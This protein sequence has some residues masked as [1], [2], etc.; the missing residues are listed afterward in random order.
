MNSQQLETLRKNIELEVSLLK[1]L[2]EF[3][4]DMVGELDRV[5]LLQSNSAYLAIDN[6]HD[7]LINSGTELFEELRNSGLFLMNLGEAGSMQQLD[8][9]D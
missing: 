8:L 1:R 3:D 6:N 5:P 2:V 9:V 4:L 7:G